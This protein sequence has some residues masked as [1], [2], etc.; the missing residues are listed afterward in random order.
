M[1]WGCDASLRS[2]PSGVPPRD[3]R[4]TFPPDFVDN[5]ETGNSST[6]THAVILKIAQLTTQTFR[7]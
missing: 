2:F 3:S 5:D 7:Q 6:N 4:A 1:G